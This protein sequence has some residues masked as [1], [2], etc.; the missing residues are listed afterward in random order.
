MWKDSP[1][2]SSWGN[3]GDISFCRYEVGGCEVVWA[4]K[5]RSISH[6]FFDE[7]AAVFFL[8]HLVSESTEKR[9]GEEEKKE[10]EEM[11]TEVSPVK[12]MRYALDKRPGLEGSLTMETM[13]GALGPDWHAD[14]KMVGKAFDQVSVAIVVVMLL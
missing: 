8:P 10:E 1:F 6:A 4:I 3:G 14:L 2:V 5:D 12:R 11:I 7:G 13:G 9:S